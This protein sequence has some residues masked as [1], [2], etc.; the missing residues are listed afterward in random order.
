MQDHNDIMLESRSARDDVGNSNGNVSS[1]CGV[2]QSI[3][4]LKME[5]FDYVEE[6]R[7]TPR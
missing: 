6:V 5:E 1:I 2:D 4:T 7:I 3:D